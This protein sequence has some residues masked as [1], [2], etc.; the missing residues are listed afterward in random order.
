MIRYLIE[1]NIVPIPKS[2]SPQRIKEN[3]EIF[4]FA[5]D[6]DD[7]KKIKGLDKDESGRIVKFDFFSEEVRDS[8]EFPFPKCQKVSAN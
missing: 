8:P 4:D 1:R 2:V 5:L 7:M 3:I 6:N